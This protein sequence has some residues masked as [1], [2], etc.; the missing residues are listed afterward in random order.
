MGRATRWALAAAA[1]AA[2]VWAVSTW[3]A[4]WITAFIH[5]VES[6]GALAPV[7]FIAG[8]AV[9][10]AALVPASIFTMAAGVLFGVVRGTVYA[11]LGATLGA[12]I[13]FLISRYVARRTVKRKLSADTRF[14][15]IDR[16]IRSHGFKV[17]F[18]LR[19]SP[20]FPF[21]IIN[22]TLGLTRVRFVDYLAASIGLI[23]PTWLYVYNG[24]LMGEVARVGI[25]HALPGGPG[26]YA[27]IALG[28][29]A[30]ILV[31]VWLT[32]ISRKALR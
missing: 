9:G 7:V 17:V 32:R 16:A 21:A 3:A 28:T 26:N 29:L 8:F 15:R 20:V 5:W 19:L 14:T 12:M 1:A 25:A 4:V 24:M 10:T 2:V 22:Y 13:A 18:L 6:Y 23:P 27:V 31:T 30:T 11:F